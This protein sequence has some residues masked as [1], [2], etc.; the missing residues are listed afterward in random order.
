VEDGQS[1]FALPIHT[2]SNPFPCRSVV[3]VLL[4]R[5]A[6]VVCLYII[7]ALHHVHHLKALQAHRRP[8]GQG[9]CPCKVGLLHLSHS[10]Q[11][12]SAFLCPTRRRS[13]TTFYFSQKCDEQPNEKGECGTCARLRL[14]C[15]GFGAKRPE[16]LRVC[17]LCHPPAHSMLT[18]QFPGAAQGDGDTGE[19]QDVLGLK[20]HDQGPL[21]Q[22]SKAG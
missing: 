5:L 2:I 3:L 10:S 18:P 12:L 13:L 20:R 6:L 16:W 8:Q 1:F 9:R 7:P 15:L 4:S 17:D 14:Q 21:N 19:D 11:G 22:P